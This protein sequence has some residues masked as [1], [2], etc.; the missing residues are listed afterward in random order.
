[1]APRTMGREEKEAVEGVE[2]TASELMQEMLLP[3]FTLVSS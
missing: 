2:D 3:M 1:M